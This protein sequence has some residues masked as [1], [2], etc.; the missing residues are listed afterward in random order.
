MT[1][2][3]PIRWFDIDPC[4]VFHA[5]NAFDQTTDRWQNH[6]TAS[7]SV[8]R[9]VARRR[10]LWSSPMM[11]SWTINLT[12]GT[13]QRSRST[14]ALWSSRTSMI[15]WL[16]C[17]RGT[18]LAWVRVNSCATTLSAALPR[19]SWARPRTG[20]P[21]RL[22]PLGAFGGG[23]TIRLVSVL[24]SRPG[25]GQQRPD[26]NRCSRTY[27]ARVA[28]VQLPRRRCP[29]GPRP[30]DGDAE[31]AQTDAR[32]TGRISDWAR[33]RW[34]GVHHHRA[35]GA[36]LTW[37]QFTGYYLR[38]FRRPSAFDVRGFPRGQNAASDLFTNDDFP[39]PLTSRLPPWPD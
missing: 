29:T 22:S 32:G 17:R 27:N 30:L 33:F 4:Y 28:R 15:G 12:R 8:S 5:L 13:R 39:T 23:R 10:D 31:N 36:I 6:C 24:C 37:T 3:G 2:F 1:H 35:W 34:D 26:N 9:V 21:G 20:G 16:V 7:N 38:D 25:T 11:W 19:R 18:E 14:S